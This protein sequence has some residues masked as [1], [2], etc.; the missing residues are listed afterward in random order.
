MKF[1]KPIIARPASSYVDPEGNIVTYGTAQP[2]VVHVRS[3]A[4][5]M[6]TMAKPIGLG[7]SAWLLGAIHDGKHTKIWQDDIYSPDRVRG[8]TDHTIFGVMYTRHLCNQWIAE[9]KKLNVEIDPVTRDALSIM[10]DVLGVCAASH[11]SGLLDMEP[12]SMEEEVH[13]QSPR[14]FYTRKKSDYVNGQLVGDL[15]AE[16]NDT[17]ANHFPELLEDIKKAFDESVVEFKNFIG[18]MGKHQAE[19]ERRYFL[20]TTIK[21]L[22]SCLVDADGTD[23]GNWDARNRRRDPK[24]RGRKN[25]HAMVK[26]LCTSSMPQLRKKADAWVARKKESFKLSNA[27]VNGVRNEF[28]AK[29]MDALTNHSKGAFV[30]YGPTGVGKTIPALHSSLHHAE[31]YKKKKILFLAPFTNIIEQNAT[32]ARE[33]LDKEFAP[34]IGK[35]VNPA[36]KT[37]NV[38]EHHSNL[39]VEGSGGAKKYNYAIYRVLHEAHSSPVVFASYARFFD[40]LLSNKI[41]DNRRFHSDIMNSVIILDECQD[42]PRQYRKFFSEMFNILIEKF[43]CTIVFCSATIPSIF[44]YGMGGVRNVIDIIKDPAELERSINQHRK[45]TED[46]SMLHVGGDGFVTVNELAEHVQGSVMNRGSALVICATKKST[47]VMYRACKKLCKDS[48]RI[49]HLSTYMVAAHRSYAIREIRK[50]LDHGIRIL[51]VTTSLIEAGVDIDF[52]VVYKSGR[53]PITSVIQAR[54]RGNRNG[55]LG[56]EGGMFYLFTLPESVEHTSHYGEARGWADIVYSEHAVLDYAAVTK[57]TQLERDFLER[58]P[59]RQDAQSVSYN[60][61]PVGPAAMIEAHTKGKKSTSLCRDDKHPWADDTCRASQAKTICSIPFREIGKCECIPHTQTDVFVP[62][63]NRG[64]RLLQLLND[65]RMG[66]EE[67]REIQHY[68]V[69]MYSQDFDLLCR[70]QSIK[71]IECPIVRA[72]DSSDSLTIRVLVDPNIGTDSATGYRDDE[73]IIIDGFVELDWVM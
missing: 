31:K 34:H 43:N 69:S 68:M 35:Y 15:I 48:Y 39:F 29:V 38:L 50:C 7:R 32:I 27:P 8:K 42:I 52:P 46:R 18:N 36:K 22:F 19:H 66:I 17:Y 61:N 26:S 59:V 45:V 57:Y 65:G 21:F 51:V 41:T 62:Y 9:R 67:Y 73:G 44:D 10:I 24:M 71:V 1:T 25:K 20:Y 53:L 56:D 12:M 70:T 3:V 11:H 64:K 47:K 72:T 28:A 37:M 23:A 54:G 33:M 60:N 14:P 6:E 58:N 63:G 40:M 13:P 55:W 16:V 49:F 2:Y 5:K 4:D 30:C